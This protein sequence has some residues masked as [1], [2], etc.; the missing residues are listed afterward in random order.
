MKIAVLNQKGGVGKSTISVNLAYGLS[1][2]KKRVLVT[3]LDPQAHASVIFCQE[4]KREQTV[5]QL[6]LNRDLN[7]EDIIQGAIVG[8]KEKDNLFIIPSNIRLAATAEQII[9]KAHREKLLHNQFKKINRK[10]DFIVI[11]C[12]PNLA[13]LTVNAILTADL[14]IIPTTYGRYS[15]DGIADLFS[16]IAEIKE[17]NSYDYQILRNLYDSRNMRT[18]NFIDSELKPHHDKILNTIIR[19]S[20]AINQAQISGEPIFSFDKASHG[21]QDFLSLTNEIIKRYV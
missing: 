2:K 11:D 5:N 9:T 6:F 17:K 15:L 10:F 3:D 14:I 18:N 8:A 20:E 1:L 4:I 13:S 12:P 7:V 19:K 21:A 16:S